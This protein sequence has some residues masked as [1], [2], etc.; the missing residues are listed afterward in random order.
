VDIG[1]DAA[2]EWNHAGDPAGI[3]LEAPDG[4]LGD[5]EFG[6]VAAPWFDGA[7]REEFA[8]TC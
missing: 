7:L 2:V 6:S 8:S 4:N 3:D 1:L 5:P